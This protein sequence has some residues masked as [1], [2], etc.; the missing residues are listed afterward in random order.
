MKNPNLRILA[1]QM[2][3]DQIH[4]VTLTQ[5]PIEPFAHVYLIILGH[6]HTVDLNAC[7]MKIVQIV[8]H[9]SI[10]NVKILVWVFV[11]LEHLVTF[12]I[13]MPF[14]SVQ[15]DILETALKVVKKFKL[16]VRILP[17][18]FFHTSILI[19]INKF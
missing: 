10:K 4:N 1:R 7:Q 15:R 2:H 6:L 8:W 17:Q 9:V 13:I 12:S 5:T 14:V 11:V 19:S 16:L 18:N 3:V